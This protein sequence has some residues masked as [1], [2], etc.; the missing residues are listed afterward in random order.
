MKKFLDEY[1]RSHR[2][3]LNQILHA[4]GIPAIVISIPWFFFNWKVA[5]GLF[6]GG[7]MLQFA[8]HVCEGTPPVFL[9]H[10]RA[11]LIAPLWWLQKIVGVG[12]KK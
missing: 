10:P 7:W 8:G 5:L 12:R 6:L 9:K 11:L 4:I 3:P 1:K 2:H